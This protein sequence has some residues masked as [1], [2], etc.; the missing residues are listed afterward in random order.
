MAG[1][2]EHDYQ[3]QA[4]KKVREF[5]EWLSDYLLKEDATTRSFCGEG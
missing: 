3:I 4:P 2:Y 1:L 5:V